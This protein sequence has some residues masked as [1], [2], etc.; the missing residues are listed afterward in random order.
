MK[1][2]MVDGHLHRQLPVSQSLS[3]KPTHQT[4]ELAQ[5]PT[6]SIIQEIAEAIP[7]PSQPAKV[8]T[9]PEPAHQP[10]EQANIFPTQVEAI[11]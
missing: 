11:F 2:K 4:D 3:T 10:T 7:E 9:I 8:E 1:F 5:Q 6:D